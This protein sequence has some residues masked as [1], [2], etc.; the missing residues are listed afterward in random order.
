MGGS[1]RLEK[2]IP[3]A[4]AFAFS[5]DWEGLPNA[6]MEAMAMGMPIVATDCPCGG[7][8]TLITH[9]QNGLLVPIKD[10]EAMA[11][12]I[13]R[14]IEEPDLAGR[15]GKEARKICEIANTDAICKQWEEYIEEII[16]NE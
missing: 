5:S 16:N 1:N 3:V 11:A 15:L 6:L 14:L 9:E 2:E 4:T 7:P 10:K 8:A 12:G 13:C